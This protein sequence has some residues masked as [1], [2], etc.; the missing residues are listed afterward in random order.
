MED[1]IKQ[2]K[3]IAKENPK[4]FTISLHDLNHV[5]KGWI[6]ALKETQNSFGD[7]GLR[8]V[9]EASKK[10]SYLMGG[11]KEGKLFYYDSVMVF[12]DKAKAIEAGIENEQIAI[13]QIETATLIYL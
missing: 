11:W 4:G 1:L 7:Q 10:T 12:E 9:I 2:I 13:Y 3:Q 8:K 6:V 5:K